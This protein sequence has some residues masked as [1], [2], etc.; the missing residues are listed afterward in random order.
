MGLAT[1]RCA[2]TEVDVE[3]RSAQP[4]QSRKR[5]GGRDHE[6]TA[7]AVRAREEGARIQEGSVLKFIRDG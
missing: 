1:N 6:R 3:A 7:A 2:G 5:G 4:R